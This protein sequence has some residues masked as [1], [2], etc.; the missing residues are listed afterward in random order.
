VDTFLEM[1]TDVVHNLELGKLPV[2]NITTFFND[3]AEVLRSMEVNIKAVGVQN[4]DIS[5]FSD[6][7]IDNSFRVEG[8]GNATILDVSYEIIYPIE[9][10]EQTEEEIHI[11]S[12][13]QEI[14][15]V[16]G[17]ISRINSEKDV[18]MNYLN[19][20]QQRE[21][22]ISVDDLSKYMDFF[23]HGL[24]RWDNELNEQKEKLSNLQKEKNAIY[25]VLDKKKKLLREIT[26][27][28]SICICCREESVLPLQLS[29]I[30]NGASW[31]SSYDCRISHEN[32]GEDICHLTYY[33]SIINTTG[34]DWIQAKASLSTANPSLGGNPPILYPLLV[35]YSQQLRVLSSRKIMKKEKRK[36]KDDELDNSIEMD[37][38]DVA[39]PPL[40]MKS[41]V[42]EKVSSQGT[43]ISYTIKQLVTIESD[44]KPHKVKIATISLPCEF[45]YV[46]VPGLS[47]KAYF[48]SQSRNDSDFQLLEGPMNVFINNVYVTQS[49]LSNVSPN[50]NFTMY[51]GVD[52]S[53]K[54]RV[55]PV[56]NM[57][58][59]QGVIFV[60]RRNIQEVKKEIV[61]TNTKLKPVDICVFQ[62][63]PFSK[64]ETI[65][66]KLTDPKP[67]EE[68]VHKDEFSILQ[69]KYKL[70][71][72]RSHTISL[73][74]TIETPPDIKNF[75][76]QEQ[77][78]FTKTSY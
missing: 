56:S 1:K 59:K 37:H 44:N 71:G 9:K 28:V 73:A 53:I 34:E 38:D 48:R 58:S 40:P 12:L 2:H 55:K 5:G 52:K 64:E 49:N 74:Y 16:E 27:K 4:I 62:Q 43:S 60:N 46:I 67:D 22:L 13:N 32:E 39:P 7:V 65:K 20:L 35:T 66:I 51:L 78:N 26:R 42:T 45:D 25:A 14:S 36:V 21:S 61:I 3:R 30:V 10:V 17:A 8:S 24:E 77:T 19:S 11:N 63:L 76:Y 33:G 15:L 29:Y 70:E 47:D 69:W 41:N 57:D 6:K 18:A 31:S 23:N 72:G 50:E 75:Y 54:I 68:N